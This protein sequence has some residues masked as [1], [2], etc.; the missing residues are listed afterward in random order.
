[1]EPFCAYI[2]SNSQR[3]IDEYPVNGVQ[4]ISRLK[5]QCANMNFADQ[6]IYNRRFQK[7]IHKVRDSEINYIKIFYHSKALLIS[8]GNSYSGGQLVHTLFFLNQRGRK[9]SS[10]I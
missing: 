1:M 8:V 10:Q 6:I 7:V 3:L 4:A 2:Y 9:D 5:Y